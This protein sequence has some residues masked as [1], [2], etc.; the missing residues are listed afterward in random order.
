MSTQNKPKPKGHGRRY[1]FHDPSM[2]LTKV[3]LVYYYS[4]KNVVLMSDGPYHEEPS[5][6]IRM[7]ELL[8]KG[9]CAWMVAYN[10]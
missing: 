2:P 5:A 3:Y 10:D 9:S 4:D 6:Y 7:R 1:I 8:I